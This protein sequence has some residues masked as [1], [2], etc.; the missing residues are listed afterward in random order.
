MAFAGGPLR[1]QARGALIAAL[2]ASTSA[3]KTDDLL[4]CSPSPSLSPSGALPDLA[5]AGHAYSACFHSQYYCLVWVCSGV[6]LERGPPGAAASGGCVSWTPADADAGRIVEFRIRTPN[7]FCGDHASYRWSVK[8]LPGP[9]IQAFTADRTV[10][11]PGTA[12]TVTALFTDGDGSWDQGSITSGVPATTPPLEA[13]VTLVLHVRNA[14]GAE[15]VATLPIHVERDPRILSFTATPAEV[16]AGDPVVLSWSAEGAL[17]YEVSPPGG[18]TAATWLDVAPEADT[19]YRLTAWNGLGVPATATAGV[20]VLPPPRI[21]ALTADPAAVPLGG[22]TRLVATFDGGIGTLERFL[23]D[24]S[25]VSWAESTSM[26]EITSGAALAGPPQDGTDTYRLM[27]TNRLGRQVIADLVVPATGPGTFALA[28][29]TLVDRQ[30]GPALVRLPDDR[31]L[32]VGGNLSSPLPRDRSAEVFDPATGS[33]GPELLLAAPRYWAGAARLDDG[34]VLIAGGG[35]GVATAEVLELST[36]TSTALGAPLEDAAWRPSVLPLAGGDALVLG[37]GPAW[38]FDA[39]A[40]GLVPASDGPAPAARV[41]GCRLADGRIL[42]TGEG[43]AWLYDELARAFTALPAPSVPRL[44]PVVLCPAGGGGLV[45]GGRGT[46]AT[47]AFIGWVPDVERFDPLAGAFSLAGS[48]AVEHTGAVEL[49]DGRFLL[50]GRPSDVY[51]PVTGAITPVGR[52]ILLRYRQW[53]GTDGVRL[54]DGRVLVH[55]TG[56]SWPE[57]FTP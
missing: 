29:R 4:T 17:E 39:A 36:G 3:C 34:R 49:A 42:L 25:A 19:T 52:T 28:A 35:R 44:D 6:E 48:V 43:Q 27:V 46:S 51:D 53:P 38:R 16:T 45:L 56:G 21:T 41:R 47:G 33:S 30:D 37:A 54:G 7:D 8:V 15:A 1:R 14:A 26:G 13:D 12:V 50:L 10:V 5:T 2:L 32:L 9:A 11:S 55:G 20:R 31:V 18:R 40:T 23:A 22:A 24:L 57:L